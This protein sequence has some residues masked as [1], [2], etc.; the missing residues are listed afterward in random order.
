L[1]FVVFLVF[2]FLGIV[3]VVLVVVLVAVAARFRGIAQV[4]AATDGVDPVLISAWN[5]TIG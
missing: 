4:S 3:V 5:G 2:F 1:V